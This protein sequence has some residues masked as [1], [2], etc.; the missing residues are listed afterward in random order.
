MKSFFNTV[1]SPRRSGSGTRLPSLIYNNGGM[2]TIAGSKLP[3]LADARRRWTYLLVA[4]IVV[5][6]FLIV[7]R[8]L[9][10]EDFHLVR[11]LLRL[12]RRDPVASGSLRVVKRGSQTVLLI[13]SQG[14][15]VSH[16]RKSVHMNGLLHE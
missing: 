15:A 12:T 3:L 11:D 16:S 1:A 9:G 13:P 8:Y 2:P 7:P 6:A 10:S 5:L 4:A 14:C